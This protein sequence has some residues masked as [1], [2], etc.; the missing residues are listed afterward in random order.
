MIVAGEGGQPGMRRST[1]R[2]ASTGPTISVS[3]GEDAAAERAVAERDDASWFGHRVV[4]GE[5]RFAHAGRDGAGDEE[6]V[7]VAR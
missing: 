6:D 1:G 4:G 2:S 7:G 3:C 5:E